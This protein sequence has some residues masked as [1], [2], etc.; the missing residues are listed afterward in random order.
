MRSNL[1]DA[2]THEILQENLKIKD[3]LTKTKIEVDKWFENLWRSAQAWAA[4]E[5]DGD[6]GGI[7]GSYVDV[8]GMQDGEEEEGE[9]EDAMDTD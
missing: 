7:G 1:R 6:N 2:L 9:E 4:R 5:R 8:P 3:S